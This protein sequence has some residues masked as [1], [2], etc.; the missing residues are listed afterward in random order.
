MRMQTKLLLFFVPLAMLFAVGMSLLSQQVVLGVIEQEVVKRGLDAVSATVQKPAFLPGLRARDESQLLPLIQTLVSNGQG[1]YSLAQDGAGRVIAHTNVA[2]HGKLYDDPLTLESVYSDAPVYRQIQTSDG[3]VLDV[4]L[5]VWD[6]ASDSDETFLLMGGASSGN[7]TR[8]GTLRLGILMLES[9]ATASRISKQ[10]TLVIALGCVLFIVMALLFNRQILKPIHLLAKATEQVRQGDLGKTVPVLSNNEM[11]DLAASFNRMSQTLAETSVSKDFLDGILN[12]MM[13]VLIVTSLDGRIRMVNRSTFTLLGYGEQEL[14]NKP[15]GHLFEGLS[16]V[17]MMDGTAGEMRRDFEGHLIAK[18]RQ[19]IPVLLSVSIPR[20]REQRLSGF[21]ITAKD[22]R[23]RL[24]AEETRRQMEL[25]LIQSERMAAVGTVA[26]GI[27][28][29]LR[30]PLTGILGFAELLKM[31][32]PD[33]GEVDRILSSGNL[34]NT[35][36]ENILAKS[37]HKRTTEDVDINRLLERELEFLMADRIF[38]RDVNK[39]VDLGEHMPSI[40]GVYTDFS[41][42][43]GNFLRNAIEAMTDRPTKNL[44]LSTAQDKDHVIVEI[45]DSGCGIDPANL[46]NLFQPFFTTKTSAEGPKGTGLG[47]YMSKRL[48]DA[49]GATISIDST[50][51]VG[52]TFNVRIPIKPPQKVTEPS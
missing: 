1:V 7:R 25:Q 28:H 8:L 3:P 49:H 29:N 11:G 30:N 52:T 48:L 38:K 15:A 32:H 47:L 46:K 16:L 12:N 19:P 21:I 33:L 45:G 14:L 50:L 27:V 10:V 13:D 20:D 2:E 17:G 35:M 36:I 26:A 9:R 23:E 39:Q 37:R 22:M 31:K 24:N 4:A 41:Q 43:F 51:N 6:T 5:P 40:H 44:R 34:M 42:V 18:D